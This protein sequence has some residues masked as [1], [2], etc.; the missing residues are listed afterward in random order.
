MHWKASLT[1]LPRLSKAKSRTFGQTIPATPSACSQ[2][3]LAKMQTSAPKAAKLMIHGLSSLISTWPR[4]FSK[5]TL[6]KS[7][8]PWRHRKECSPWLRSA[9]SHKPHPSLSSTLALRI[10]R[11]QSSLWKVSKCSSKLRHKSSFTS[12]SARISVCKLCT[13][14][15]RSLNKNKW[16]RWSMRNLPCNIFKCTSAESREWKKWRSKLTMLRKP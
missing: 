14:F 1:N 13:A 16:R 4:F 8:S 3:F 15:A 11:M 2:K 12:S 9:Q 5:L 7:S 10:W 6:T